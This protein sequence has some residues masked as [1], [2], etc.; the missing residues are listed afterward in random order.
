M[1]HV[2]SLRK[3]SIQRASSMSQPKTASPAG[4][5]GPADPRQGRD[6]HVPTLTTSLTTIG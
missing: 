1:S 6:F 3:E 4:R 5:P 2:L